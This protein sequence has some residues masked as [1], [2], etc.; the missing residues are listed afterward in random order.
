MRAHGS[1]WPLLVARTSSGSAH[2]RPLITVC[3]SPLTTSSFTGTGVGATY[4][5]GGW[6]IVGSTVNA[7]VAVA[8]PAAPATR[9]VSW[10]CTDSPFATPLASQRNR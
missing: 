5:A 8:G 6:A 9:G 7:P 2:W 1:G 3:A 4:G 10:I